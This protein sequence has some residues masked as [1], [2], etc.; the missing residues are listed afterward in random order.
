MKPEPTVG[1]LALKVVTVPHKAVS[2]PALAIV[3]GRRFSIDTVSCVIGQFPVVQLEINAFVPEARPL[4]PEIGE[5]ESS[6]TPVPAITV[7]TPVPGVGL[8]AF[9]LAV[10]ELQT[11]NQYRHLLVLVMNRG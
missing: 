9:K 6:K 10:S 11:R 7:Q 4:I 3:G 5:V 1:L 2:A 8:A